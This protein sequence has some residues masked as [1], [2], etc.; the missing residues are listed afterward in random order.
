MRL[1]DR[2]KHRVHLLN[3]SLNVQRAAKG[4][5]LGIVRH[6]TELSPGRR[7]PC[8]VRCHHFL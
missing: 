1:I 5:L 8:H 4:G 3:G 6:P 7:W 2:W